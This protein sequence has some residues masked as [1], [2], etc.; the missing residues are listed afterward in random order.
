MELQIAQN[1]NIW[2]TDT[3]DT[4]RRLLYLGRELTLKVEYG[5]YDR[6][7]SLEGDVLKIVV[8]KNHKEQIPVMLE[9]WYRFK[10][11]QVLRRMTAYYAAR[12]NLRVNRITIKDQKTRWGSCSSKHNL[13]YNYRLVMAPEKVMEY[14][15]IHELCHLIHMNH[16]REFWNEVER[17]QPEYRQYRK[18]LKDHQNDLRL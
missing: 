3:Y 9:H 15:V 1:E 12:M 8:T 17:L 16:S 13:N 5:S 2:N 18:W 4:G 11:S 10:A 7:A 14:V 6:G